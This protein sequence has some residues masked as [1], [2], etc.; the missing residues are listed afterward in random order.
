MIFFMDWF[1]E[2]LESFIIELVKV[3]LLANCVGVLLGMREYLG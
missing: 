2:P 3:Y 1:P